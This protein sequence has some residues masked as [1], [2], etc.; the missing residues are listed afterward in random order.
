MQLLFLTIL[1]PFSL[2]WVALSSFD[3]IICTESYYCEGEE[4]LGEE[5]G[6]VGRENY[7]CEGKLQLGCNM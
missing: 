3:V 6:G 1:G 4:K 2:S 5:A 7:S